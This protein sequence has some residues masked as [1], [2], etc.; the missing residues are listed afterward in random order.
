MLESSL[1]E[2]GPVSTYPVTLYDGPVQNV[3][4]DPRTLQHTYLQ[5]LYV[6]VRDGE[7][8]LLVAAVRALA[9]HKHAKGP[10]G[11][12]TE[13]A[14][15]Y[16]AAKRL[17]PFSVVSGHYEPGHRHSPDPQK[18]NPQ[19]PNHADRCPECQQAGAHPPFALS[20]VKFAE[21]DDLNDPEQL[22]AERYRL[23][24]HPSVIAC[25]KSPGGN[26]LHIFVLVEPSPTTDAE[27]HAVHDT[28]YAALGITGTGDKSVKNLARLAF[29]SHDPDAYWNPDPVPLVCEIPDTPENRMLNGEPPSG[30]TAH[31]PLG[32]AS[33]NSGAKS[34]TEGR[35]ARP[36]VPERG[37]DADGKLVANALSAMV[38]EKAGLDDHHLL[39]VMGNLKALG[40]SFEEF[41]Q[42][43]DAA[44]CTCERR[45]RWDN[46]PSGSQSDRPGWAIVNLAAKHYGFKKTKA[47]AKSKAGSLSQTATAADG[48]PQARWYD[49]GQ[50]VARQVLHPRFFWDP[51]ARIF[52]GWKD[53]HWEMIPKNAPDIVDCL[54]RKQFAL[55]AELRRLAAEDSAVMA[56]NTRQWQEQCRSDTSSFNTGVR[57]TLVRRLEIPPD[58]IIA[59]TNGVLNLQE[60]V[61]Y[62]HTPL[63]PYLITAVMDGYYLDDDL[64]VL[65]PILTARLSPAIPDP[66]R[67]QRLYKALTVCMG[68]KGGTNLRGS[69]IYLYGTSGGGKGNTTRVLDRTFGGY[70]MTGNAQALTANSEIKDALAT[71][72]ERMPRLV[73]FH[74]VSKLPMEKIL[75]MTGRDPQS[76]R[77]P[78]KATIERSLASGV[79]VTAVDVPTGRMDTGAKRRL[80]AIKFEGR[81]RVNRKDAT[82]DTTQEV[83]DALVTVVLRDAITMWRD[84]DAW[85]PLPEDDDDTGEARRAAD[86]VEGYIDSLTD[87]HVG[88]TIESLLLKLQATGDTV[89]AKMNARSLSTRIN[90]R[91]NWTVCRR[92]H[93]GGDKVARLFRP[94]NPA[95]ENQPEQAFAGRQNAPG[96]QN[97][98][99]QNA[100]GRQNSQI[101]GSPSRGGG[102]PENDVFAAQ[103]GFAARQTDVHA[104][105]QLGFYD[106]LNAQ[107][108]ADDNGKEPFYLKSQVPPPP[109]TC[110]YTTLALEAAKLRPGADR[111][112]VLATARMSAKF[113]ARDHGC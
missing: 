81:A 104:K 93:G 45:G 21:I 91:E 84:P 24:A 11:K 61:L 40:Q 29:G 17:L 63:G 111:N 38:A 109:C 72:L 36:G 107:D 39:A 62:P 26:G 110:D 48:P 52:W 12:L 10:D 42:W 43:A 9:A 112:A 85:V 106:G 8:E 49:I 99:R 18:P 33:T 60:D 113:C 13:K 30:E 15:A 65:Y 67:R 58:Y 79:I 27:A 20:G 105:K 78:H 68:G 69:L 89:A 53:D 59:V 55:A 1:P 28:V 51:D 57:D 102:H 73:A 16:D 4:S 2:T 44:G 64:A 87:D 19:Q 32:A 6:L 22:A 74:E 50:W 96:R 34:P 70:V 3:G 47:K 31:E 101:L 25:W 41:D 90:K 7:W 23:Q 56:G 80:V 94:D 14:I 76:A 100:P 108:E 95:A 83:R 92:R 88:R 66:E 82:D 97:A 98:G 103:N 75:S 54:H 71:M 35:G 5:C 77:G 86:M 46:P 37:H